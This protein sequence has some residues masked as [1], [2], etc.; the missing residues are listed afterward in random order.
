M[1]LYDKRTRQIGKVADNL[2]NEAL[3]SGNYEP[4]PGIEIPVISPD[5]QP[6]TLLSDELSKFVQAGGRYRTAAEDRQTADKEIAQIKQET[7][8]NP[9]LAATTAVLRGGSLGLSDV[10][11]RG[12]GELT[13]KGKETADALR[14]LQ[15]VNPK[16]SLAGEIAGGIASFAIPVTG[17]ANVLGRGAQTAAKVLGAPT[18]AITALGETAAKT[19]VGAGKAFD[20]LST[21]QK[22]GRA[23]VG[24][25]TEGMLIGAGQTLSEAALSDPDLTVQKAIANV[26]L[27]GLFGGA[28]S[29]TGR[30][31]FEAG[32]TAATVI[33]E[34]ISKTSLPKTAQEFM[35][36]VAEKYGAVNKATRA[37]FEPDARLDE[38]WSRNNQEGRARAVEALNNPAKATQDFVDTL[39]AG[40][41]LA[42]EVG[43]TASRAAQVQKG[44]LDA[45]IGKV[46]KAIFQKF[47]DEWSDEAEL[48]DALGIDGLLFRPEIKG[49]KLEVAEKSARNA[50]YDA[51]DIEARKLIEN[52]QSVAKQM[53]DENIARRG[54][55]Y[56]PGSIAI[57]EDTQALLSKKFF[58]ESRTL[59]DINDALVTAKNEL[60][61]QGRVFGRNP[62]LMSDKEFRSNKKLFSVWQELKDAT[63][64]ENIFGEFGAAVAKRADVLT[65]IKR[66]T[67]EF[68]KQFFIDR[69]VDGKITRIANERAQDLF[70]R[71][72]GNS[73]NFKKE[74]AL[75][76]FKSGV[77]KAIEKLEPLPLQGLDNEIKR[78]QDLAKQNQKRAVNFAQ[79][80]GKERAAK[81][82]DDQIS[83][84]QAQRENVIKFNEDMASTSSFAR[85]K[86]TQLE[87]QLDG[88]I[89]QKL[90]SKLL[91][92]LQSATGRS[93]IGGFAG[94]NLGGAGEFIGLDGNTSKTIGGVLGLLAVNPVSALRYISA[95]ETAAG[96]LDKMAQNAATRFKNY[97]TKLA[98]KQGMST[99]AVPAIR[100]TIIRDRLRIE[101]GERQQETDEKAFKEHRKKLGALMQNPEALFD[102]V[103][104][105]IGEEG[106]QEGPLMTIESFNI[107]NRGLAFLN[108]K[109]PKDPYNADALS[110]DDF[111]P[112]KVELMEYSDYAQAV[113]KPKT[114]IKQIETASINP[115][116]VEAIKA[117]YPKMY[118]DV[119]GK[120]TQSLVDSGNKI[121]YAQRVQLGLLFDIPSTK[122]MQPDYLARI[123]SYNAPQEQQQTQQTQQ[124]TRSQQIAFRDMK[125]SDRQQRV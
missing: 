44:V 51:A 72:A 121:P 26:G 114:L 78:L 48:A 8:D 111:T 17:A 46:D 58:E 102:K 88:T 37:D 25:T 22:L 69:E 34:K 108:S 1:L 101:P 93:L 67:K 45:D 38:L 49:T 35:G 59:T 41:D 56:D 85:S 82:L 7:F 2:V 20:E 55:V 105:S 53:Q 62:T 52:I 90:T 100:Q 70:I 66:A 13:G 119:L 54:E 86:I 9:A 19:A 39:T 28:L 80:P 18:R 33:P 47:D 84:M 103:A 64:D 94:Y 91:N 68:D 14:A 43:K 57:L 36:W 61:E 81:F 115:R 29:A 60:A 99:K 40:R 95:M 32:R 92:K 117:V 5:G 106:M 104:A 6:G 24:G 16:A 123:M 11:L 79:K 65:E 83:N 3:A 27:G 77:N 4:Q 113:F 75:D 116:T 30:G 124:I 96:G 97:D 50:R 110:S 76:D 71:N 15:E 74:L 73:A 118:D 23:A 122:A 10:A 120:V 42:D 63:T 125:A 107:A 12:I 87:Q 31:I 112:S 98:I 109:I 89:E 21:L